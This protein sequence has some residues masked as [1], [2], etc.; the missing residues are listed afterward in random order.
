MHFHEYRWTFDSTI[1]H[2]HFFTSM[3]SNECKDVSYF[4]WQLYY[5]LNRLFRRTWS[6]LIRLSCTDPLWQDFTGDQ[7]N[8]RTKSQQWGKRSSCNSR[9]GLPWCHR[10]NGKVNF[11]QKWHDMRNGFHLP[12]KSTVCSTACRE[13]M[14]EENKTPQ[15][16]PSMMGIHLWAKDSPHI[17]PVMQKHQLCNSR[18]K[19]LL[20]G[21][22]NN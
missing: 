12:G 3:A 16:W 20:K 19:A 14:T 10:Y 11:T 5:L 15:H 13:N 4:H 17:R 8:L 18:I 6:K 9:T 21:N 22:I 1:I 7:W 2:T